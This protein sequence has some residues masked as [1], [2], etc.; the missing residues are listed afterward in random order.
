MQLGT[1]IKKNR[2]KL[3]LSQEELANKVFVSRQ[4]ISNWET[5]KTY[6]DI[7]S[8][9]LLSEIFSISLDSLIKGDIEEMKQEISSQEKKE[10]QKNSRIFTILFIAI[11]LLP[12][13]LVMLFKW[14]GFISYLIIYG[15]T[16]YYAFHIEAY[17]KRYDI[18]TYQ[19]IIAFMEDRNL[20]AIERKQEQGKR[21]YQKALL[22]AG[23]SLLVVVVALVIIYIFKIL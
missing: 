10:F 1:Q 13:P 8:L 9:L 23:F 4:S 17:K 14:W 18:Q 16:M 6:P 19:E 2:K 7:Q 20:N 3:S 22:S 12:V 11:I 15:I 21:S 5:N